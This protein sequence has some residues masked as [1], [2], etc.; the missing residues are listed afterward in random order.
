MP[1][2]RRDLLTKQGMHEVPRK[3]PP[4]AASTFISPEDASR[5]SPDFRMTPPPPAPEPEPVGGM[6]S[7]GA[8]G[9]PGAAS[10]GTAAATGQVPGGVVGGG[11]DFGNRNSFLEHA[12]SKIGFNPYSY[13]P[14]EEVNQEIANNIEQIFNTVFHGKINWHDRSK[15]TEQQQQIWQ[16]SLKALRARGMEKAQAKQQTALNELNF[17]MTQFDNAQQEAK[18]RYEREKEA[19]ALSKKGIDINQ[20]WVDVLRDGTR[21][22]K[23]LGANGKVSEID[24][25]EGKAEATSPWE[26][27]KGLETLARGLGLLGKGETQDALLASFGEEDVAAAEGREPHWVRHDGLD[28]TRAIV[29][30]AIRRHVRGAA[31]SQQQAEMLTMVETLQRNGIS[32]EE[33][34]EITGKMAGTAAGEG[35]GGIAPEAT[36]KGVMNSIKDLPPPEQASKLREA[37]DHITQV[38]AATPEPEKRQ[39]LQKERDELESQIGEI[40]RQ[41][42]GGTAEQAPAAP[43][44]AAG[45]VDPWSPGQPEEPPPKKAPEESGLVEDIAA[46]GRGVGRALSDVDPKVKFAAAPERYVRRNAPALLERAREAIS[47]L[48]ESIRET[49]A[50]EKIAQEVVKRIKEEHGIDILE[51]TGDEDRGFFFRLPDGTWVDEFNNPVSERQLPDTERVKLKRS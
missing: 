46:V 20:T 16:E 18:T 23:V 30:D 38:I 29:L 44:E 2:T 31:M 39:R 8:P 37:V 14:V 40:T 15:M 27:P 24:R 6:V 49:E 9:M 12:I 13:N 33:I 36:A 1:T 22:R 17:M 35:A 42:R 25:V 7:P 47:S 11:L 10:Q 28:E 4:T 48:A 19:A 41:H 34:L 3:G 5:L 32:D 51:Y 45:P 26:L 50:G 43:A 21:V